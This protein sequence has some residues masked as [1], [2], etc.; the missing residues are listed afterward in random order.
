M[1]KYFL[2]ATLLLFN[3]LLFGQ[4]LPEIEI[5]KDYGN[6]SFAE[7]ATKVENEHHIK[8]FY[9]K[10][11]IEHLHLPAID[12][13]V[14]LAELLNKLLLP[15]DLHFVDFQGNVVVMPGRIIV[16]E[17]KGV[18]SS[19]V[20]IGNPLE[21]GKYKKATVS[22]TILD[23]KS[24]TPIPGAQVFC[25]AL[26]KSTSSDSNGKFSIELPTGKHQLKFMFMGLNEEN[27]EII[28]HSNGE[29]EIELYEKTINIG[30][31]NITAEKPEDNFRSTSMGMVKLN[32]KAIKKLSVFMG[33]ADVIKGMTM[34][35]GVQSVGENASGFNVR[36][37]NID[38][39]LILV[40]DAPVYN[41]SHLF[42]LFT[43]L[44]PNVISDVSL[45]KSGIPARYGGRVSSV[46][47][48]ELRK[49]DVEKITVNGGL[50]II[51]SRLSVEGPIV[52]NKLTFNAGARSTYSDWMLK[53]LKNYEL[54]QSSVSFNDFNVKLD[55]TP[56]KKNRVSLFGYGSNDYFYYYQNAEY[57]YGNL[58]GAAKWSTIYNNNNSGN[59]SVNFSKYNANISDFSNKNIEYTLKTNIEQEQVAYHFSSNIFV[60][61]KVNA[62]ASVIRYVIDPGF[63]TPYSDMSIAP[64]VDMDNE[65]AIESAVYLEDEYDITP[66]LALIAGVRYANF[67]LLGPFAEKTYSA[68]SPLNAE[69]VAG[70]VTYGNG[71][72]A[73]MF[74]ALEPRLALRWEFDNLS[75][76][77]LGYNRTAQNLRQIS[78]SASI[79]PADYWKASDNYISPLISDQLAVGFFKNIDNNKYETSLELY[80]KNIQNEV[81]YK[82]GA[83]LILNNDLEQSLIHGV[84]RAYGA[85]LLIKKNSGDL[86]GWLAYTYSRSF[87][88]MDGLYHEEKINNG[89]WYRSNYD[90]PHDFTLVVNYKIS[91]RFTFGGNFTYSTGRPVTLPEQKYFI[92]SHELVTYSDRNKYR[93]PDYHRLD[94]AFTYEG[95]LK[96]KQLWRN[97]WT[98]S[99]YNVY[100]RNNPFSIYYDKQ[101]PSNLNDY[102]SYALYKF[103]IIGVPVPSFTYNFWF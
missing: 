4:K 49:S 101:K 56:D 77:K 27:R 38:Q 7:F 55:Y 3:S 92:G 21:Q 24:K 18:G 78:N 87:K 82:N 12:K 54:Q 44:D 84:G 28:L 31:I 53:L 94:L 71:E 35:P 25:E 59:L 2:L 73:K 81:D 95:S 10:E 66:E 51:N 15:A 72:L 100:G 16:S 52:K 74:H 17:N 67:M 23:G 40:H 96:K 75:S 46:M 85:E 33:E 57:G 26:S 65:N 45:Y 22:G 90:K 39:N 63:S 34:L 60:R 70:D 6:L 11:W 69:T 47:N 36:G 89:H 64:V 32:M 102:K 5:G 62:G 20:V 93:L 97:S 50:G 76:V 80:Y 41:T 8:L 9:K 88:K 42:G 29:M 98:F 68:N 61:H 91:R 48:I 19:V 13:P 58:I 14:V 99:V 83:K 43:M 1:Y 103:S 37:G 79:T 86:T 30:Q